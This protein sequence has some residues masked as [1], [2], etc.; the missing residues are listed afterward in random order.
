MLVASISPAPIGRLKTIRPFS[1]KVVA[2]QAVG[3]YPLTP[4]YAPT[5]TGTQSFYPHFFAGLHM[6]HVEE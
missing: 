2:P 1:I 4:R 3:I 6:I 5:T